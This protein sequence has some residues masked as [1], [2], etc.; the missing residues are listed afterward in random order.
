VD[1]GAQVLVMDDGLQNPTLVKTLSFLVIDGGFGFGNGRVLPAGPLR[2]TVRAAASRSDAVVLIGRDQAGA[3]ASLPRHL[4]VLRAR[5]QAGPEIGCV[6]GSRVVAFAGIGRPEKFFSMLMAAGV[7]VVA[8]L[9]FPDHH[10][11]A[12][13]ELA[14]ILEKARELGAVPVTTPK[15]L[16]RVPAA[17][18]PQFTCIGVSLAWDSQAAVEAMLDRTL[19]EPCPA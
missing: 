2:E 18:R 6:V 14:G 1:A 17:L 8:R 12:E 3:L 5:L 7:S 9:P 15:D 19:A 4:P 13:R 16:V 10:P 11:F